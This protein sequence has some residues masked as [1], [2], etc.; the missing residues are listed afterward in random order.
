MAPL[1]NTTLGSIQGLVT[2]NGSVR[3]FFGV[4]YAQPPVGKLRFNDPQAPLPWNGTYN[5][6]YPKP[7]CLQSNG[8]YLPQ[9]MYIQ[10]PYSAMDCLYMN[11]WTPASQPPQQGWPVLVFLPGVY[12]HRYVHI[13]INICRYDIW[14]LC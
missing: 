11:I 12:I 1:V 10:A 6:T 4:P 3:T 13:H 7:A 2:N 8:F 9:D 5:A 14:M